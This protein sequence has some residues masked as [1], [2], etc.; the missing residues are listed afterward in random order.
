[1]PVNQGGSTP[2]R[3]PCVLSGI[4][5]PKRSCDQGE[6]VLSC[7]HS[8]VKRTSQSPILVVDDSDE[9]IFLFRLLLKRIGATAPFLPMLSSS[10]AVTWLETIAMNEGRLDRPFVCF[11]DVKMPQLGGFDVLR[12]IR[13]MA[14]FDRLPVVMLS[15]SDDER[16]IRAAAESGAQAYLTKYPSTAVL[17][18]VLAHASAFVDGIGS[19]AFDLPYNLLNSQTALRRT[20]L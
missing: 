7:R 6:P 1:M 5:S 4:P 11:L 14:T 9:D 3:F 17:S 10:A 2:E 16:D 8:V 12:K 20:G 13:S 18:E 19:G 15:S